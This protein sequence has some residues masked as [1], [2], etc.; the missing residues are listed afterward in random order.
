MP[1]NVGYEMQGGAGHAFDK[2]MSIR[3]ELPGQEQVADGDGVMHRKQFTCACSCAFFVIWI[4][5]CVNFSFFVLML[6]APGN[7]ETTHGLGGNKTVSIELDVKQLGWKIGD[8]YGQAVCNADSSDCRHQI[9]AHVEIGIE[10][11]RGSVISKPTGK[12]AYVGEGIVEWKDI[13]PQLELATGKELSICGKK[14]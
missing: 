10:S 11:I 1:R 5:A 8:Y 2:Q 3:F 13:C 14:K 12:K 9:E 6:V 7:I 4:F